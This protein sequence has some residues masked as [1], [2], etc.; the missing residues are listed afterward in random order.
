M[1]N[2]YCYECKPVTLSS[3]VQSKID[4][5]VENGYTVE[6]I[7]GSYLDYRK[8]VTNSNYPFTSSWRG[9][10]PADFLACF[11]S[12]LSKKKQSRC[13]VLESEFGIDNGIVFE[14]FFGSVKPSDNILIINPHSQFVQSLE[15]ISAHI[16]I[17]YTDDR[18]LKF[19]EGI[20]FAL[21]GVR[22]GCVDINHFGFASWIALGYFICFCGIKDLNK[23]RPEFRDI[24]PGQS[25]TEQPVNK[26]VDIQGFD[27]PHRFGAKMLL[28]N[29][30]GILIVLIG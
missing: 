7:L 12:L 21:S 23:H 3:S 9:V 25:F 6:H 10:T 5:F 15:T 2:K 29:M 18:Y 27:L 13:L 16:T 22:F 20:L 1:P 17:T 4:K 26:T 24:R 11:C 28:Q 30:Q 14:R 8:G 19:A